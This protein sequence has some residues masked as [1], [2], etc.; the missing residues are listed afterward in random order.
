MHFQ[1]VTKRELGEAGLNV[2]AFVHLS[3]QGCRSGCIFIL[4]ACDT[5]SD[6]LHVEVDDYWKILSVV[7]SS[8]A[9]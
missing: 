6:R 7:A 1:V 8:S 4:S 2:R 9:N 5:M 3:Q